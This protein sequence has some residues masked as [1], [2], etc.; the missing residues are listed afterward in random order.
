MTFEQYLVSEY[1]KHGSIDQV[2]KF[3]NY[4][5]P[6]S[7]AGYHRVLNKFEIV[8]SAGPN[9]KLS[10]SL[11]LLSLLNTYKLPLERVYHHYAP[12]S[13]QVS[14]NTL[15]RILH[16]IRLGV[17]RRVGAAL[18]IST[19]ESPGRYLLAKDKSLKNDILGQKGDWSLP[20]GFTREQDSHKTSII[21]VLQQEVFTEQAITNRFPNLKLPEKEIFTINIADI[22][23]YVYLV[24]LP[25]KYPNFSSFKLKKHQFL[26]IS[27]LNTNR[28]RPGV[29]DILK[30]YE[31]HKFNQNIESSL[32]LS[33]A[34]APVVK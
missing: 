20:M 13:I 4:D 7:F 6:I 9:S 25:K 19:Q 3:H 1:F 14:T 24:L 8:K 27:E 32:N 18:I 34:Y 33:L 29:I 2:F 11:H 22:K 12:Q 30:N 31:E 17:T 5:I 16:H 21:R 10:E 23:V 15:H 28:V 26:G